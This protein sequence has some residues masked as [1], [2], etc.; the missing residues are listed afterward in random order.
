M[1]LAVIRPPQPPGASLPGGSEN[2]TSPGSVG[3]APT[4]GQH[5]M[6]VL[7]DVLGYPEERITELLISGALE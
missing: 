3:P 6:E 2:L 5:L 4:L 1:A 7:E